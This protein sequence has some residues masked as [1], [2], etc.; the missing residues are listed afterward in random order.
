MA[1]LSAKTN[2]VGMVLSCPGSSEIINCNFLLLMGST[3]SVPKASVICCV[4]A[5]GSEGFRTSVHMTGEGAKGFL[6]L[7][8]KKDLAP[9]DSTFA[10]IFPPT[11]EALQGPAHSLGV[12]LR[13]KR[14]FAFSKKS[15]VTNG[16][17]FNSS[18]TRF[19][20]TFLAYSFRAETSTLNCSSCGIASFPLTPGILGIIPYTGSMVIWP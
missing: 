6:T 20:A 18:V 1:S 3:S 19:Y 7:F 15:S 5:L 9:L 17:F 16:M 10:Q 13:I 8:T 12:Y 4:L 14:L 11:R 2:L